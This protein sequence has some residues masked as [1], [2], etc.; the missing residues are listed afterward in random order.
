M[1]VTKIRAIYIRHGDLN[2]GSYDDEQ[3][4]YITGVF[5][6]CHPNVGKYL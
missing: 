3:D 1:Q 2:S 6:T 5:C 4:D